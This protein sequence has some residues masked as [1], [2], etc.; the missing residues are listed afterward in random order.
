MPAEIKI[1][2]LGSVK[3]M[4]YPKKTLG[5]PRFV[6]HGLAVDSGT[7]NIV[8]PEDTGDSFLREGYGHDHK[9]VLVL[10]SGRETFGQ[11]NPNHFAGDCFDADDLSDRIFLSE[12]I[13]HYSLAQNA[14]RRG[15]F[16]IGSSEECPEP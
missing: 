16:H 5:L 9:V 1:L 10:A 15:S 8:H 2:G 6:G 3:S 11:Q 13:F 7:E 14:N 12:K 4:T